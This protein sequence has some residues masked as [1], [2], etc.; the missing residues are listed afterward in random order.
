MAHDKDMLNCRACDEAR[1]L[2]DEDLTI[3]GT[4]YLKMFSDGHYDHVPLEGLLRY[5]KDTLQ[6]PSR[7]EGVT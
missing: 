5:H 1:R 3:Y 2:K 6:E 4:G 7:D